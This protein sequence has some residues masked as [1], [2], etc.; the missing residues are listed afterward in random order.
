MRKKQ[1]ERNKHENSVKYLA[2]HKAQFI[3]GIIFL[4][5][6]INSLLLYDLGMISFLFAFPHFFATGLIPFLVGLLIIA[7]NLIE[8]EQVKV[9][10][11]RDSLQIEVKRIIPLKKFD[12][13]NFKISSLRYSALKYRETRTKRW[14]IT[15]ILILLTIEVHY[16]NAIDLLGHARISPMLIIWTIMLGFGI[17]IFVFTPKRWIEIAN[18][19]ETIFLPYSKTSQRKKK[20]LFKLLDIEADKLIKR[21]KIDQVKFNIQSHLLDFILGIF[22]LIFA[23]LLLIAPILYFGAFTRTILLIYAFKLI[24]RVLNGDPYFSLIDRNK[25]NRFYIGSSPRFTYININTK[26]IKTQKSTSFFP[27][28]FHMLEILAIIYLIFQAIYYGFR[29]FWWEYASFSALYFSL[30]SVLIVLLFLR[31][32]KPVHIEKIEF[33]NQIIKLNK[34]EFKKPKKLLADLSESFRQIKNHTDLILSLVLF[35]GF[36]IWPIVY[37]I[38]GGD[39]LIL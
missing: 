7:R 16:Q 11:K 10:K 20:N 26:K 35:I 2:F 9:L 38:F 21:N 24:L 6:G 5:V 25:P 8:G 33:N 36:L 1:K 3:S 27:L 23:L 22:L 14:L 28:R 13:I 4:S 18:E 39:F 29:N 32:I 15:F 37:I 17:I 34:Q 19:R 30:S 12:P 31:W